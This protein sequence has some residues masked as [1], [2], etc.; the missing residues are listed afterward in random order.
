MTEE[1]R[2]LLAA[3]EDGLPLVPRPYAEI[4]RRLGTGEEETIARLERMLGNG[5]I[6]RLGIV[7]RHHELGYTANAM[8]VW[9]VP[10]DRVD[11]CGERLSRLPFV[12]LCYRREARP[13]V[14]PYNLYC[15]IHGRRRDHVIELIER[16][17]AAAGLDG[18]AREILFS[19]RRFKQRGARYASARPAVTE[20]TGM[21]S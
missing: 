10:E 16:A 12:T 13:P 2:Q 18:L 9:E 4:G 15:M 19:R 20:T 21:A 14:W 3:I 1:D 17:T 11:R 6:R 5:V 8:V 7:V